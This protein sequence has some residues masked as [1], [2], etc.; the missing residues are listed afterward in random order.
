MICFLPDKYLA[1]IESLPEVSITKAE[2]DSLTY[3]TAFM[4]FSEMDYQVAKNAFDKYLQR[5][6]GGIFTNDAI[7]YNLFLFLITEFSSY[8]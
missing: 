5:F 6:D 3:N 7:Y 4:K 8:L 1:V 2:Q